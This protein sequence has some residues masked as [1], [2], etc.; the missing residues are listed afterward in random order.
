MNYIEDA[1]PTPNKLY[2][3]WLTREYAKGRIKRL[4]DM[5]SR[6]NTWLASHFKYKNKRD[7]PPELKDIMRIDAPSFLTGMVNYEPPPEELKNKGNSKLVADT[8]S[9][10]VIVPLDQD[11]ACYYGQGTQWCTA[12]TRGTNYFDHYDNNGPLYI[13]L[14]K[15]PKYNGEKYQLHFYDEQFMD[16]QDNEVYI[17]ALLNNRFPDLKEFFFKIEPSLSTAIAFADDKLLE[18]L[19]EIMIPPIREQIWDYI[20]DME[21]NDDY[22]RKWQEDKARERGYLL[23][24]DGTPFEGDVDD[25]DEFDANNME[26]DWDRAYDDEDINDYTDFNDDARMLMKDSRKL[27]DITASEI[28]NI[29]ET[30]REGGDGL[31]HVDDLSEVLEKY[32]QWE[33]G[34]NMVTRVPYVHLASTSRAAPEDIIGRVGKYIVAMP[35]KRR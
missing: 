32:I 20:S 33:L 24:N 11:A 26:I 1:D 18:D 30:L 10:R 4:E 31:L 21:S 35:K 29:A 3:P 34:H 25:L 12:A 22:F 15:H 27:D 19:V 28:K 14:P 2:T 16:E 5:D 9:A 13:I 8:P 6:Y 17:A 23:N 7:F